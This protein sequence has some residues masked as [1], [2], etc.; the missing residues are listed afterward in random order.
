MKRK[1]IEI[2]EE[3]CNGCGNCIPNCPE[4]ALQI[5]D[6]K[7]RLISDLFCDGLGACIGSC[8]Q[9]AIK[10]VEKEAEPYNEKKTM[11]N[12]IKQG[13]NTII[14]H[15]KHLHE[16]GETE[17]LKQALEVLKEK[18]IEVDLNEVFEVPCCP[19]MKIVD[20]TNEEEKVGENI[21]IKSQ[22]RQWPIQLHLVNPNAPYFKKAD[23]L[24]AADCTA[25][26]YG[27]FHNDF[28]KGKTIIIGCPKLDQGIDRYID[29]IKQIVKNNN[30]NTITVAIMEVPC[31]SGLLRI[32][33][34]AIE[35]SGK[36]IPIKK[37]VISLEGEIL[38]ESWI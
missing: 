3:K 38:E 19:G 29:K 5:I 27:N 9:D 1:I 23:L 20:R 8:P 34:E 33:E 4:G 12:I 2:D 35:N 25:F 10:I 6:G 13:K 24:V 17:Y 15:L 26:S 21:E 11:E 7:A 16:H 14:A 32:V 30:I 36:K 28:I 37:V 31:C 18:D 22:L